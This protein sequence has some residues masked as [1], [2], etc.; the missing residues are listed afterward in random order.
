MDIAKAFDMVPHAAIHQSLRRKGIPLAVAGYIK[1]MYSSYKT[2]IKT[3][4]DKA[5]EI[6]LKRGVKQRDP[7]SPLLFNLTLDSIIEDLSASTIGVRIQES[8]IAV[9]AFA[10]DMVL[11]AENKKEAKTQIRKLDSFLRQLGME[12]SIE[13]CSTFE[14]VATQKT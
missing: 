13:K 9:L 10:D 1:K 11:L 3:K 5:I 14:V 12:L 8:N 2:K 6:E 7:L 4:D